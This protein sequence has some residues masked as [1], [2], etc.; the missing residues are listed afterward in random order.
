MRVAIGWK[1]VDVR[2]GG[3]SRAKN[4]SLFGRWPPADTS[5]G[6]ALIIVGEWE[7]YGIDS[8]VDFYSVGGCSSSKVLDQV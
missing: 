6:I 7:W 5:L 2:S 3:S 4:S 8:D 1:G